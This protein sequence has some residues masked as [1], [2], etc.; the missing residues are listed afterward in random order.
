[1]QVQLTRFVLPSLVACAM[2]KM[3]LH[4][5]AWDYAQDQSASY[6]E[7]SFEDEESVEARQMPPASTSNLACRLSQQLNDQES[8]DVES[9]S[10]SQ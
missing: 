5:E 3:R 9:A 6:D 2:V 10:S 8:I 7:G 4:A 1:M